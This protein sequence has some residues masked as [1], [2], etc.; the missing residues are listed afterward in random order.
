[1]RMSSPLIFI[2][3]FAL[4][5]VDLCWAQD[6]TV[7]LNDTRVTTSPP[8]LKSSSNWYEPT[9]GGIYW[10]G[11]QGDSV[12]LTF[13]GVRAIA[14]FWLSSKGQIAQIALD[15]ANIAQFS[16]QRPDTLSVQCI[17]AQWISNPLSFGEHT[18]TV[19]KI[20]V[21]EYVRMSS[22]VY[23]SPLPSP[24]PSRKSNKTAIIAGSVGGGVGLILILAIAAF[25]LLKRKKSK[26][27]PEPEKKPIIDLLP[28]SPIGYSSQQSPPISPEPMSPALSYFAQSESTESAVKGPRAIH[29]K[30]YPVIPTDG[31]LTESQVEW[32][33]SLQAQNLPAPTLAT[34]I[35]SLT[36]AGGTSPGGARANLSRSPSDG[37]PAASGGAHRRV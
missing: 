29:T 33:Q 12:S 8:S 18:V 5:L 32:L 28:T 10:L 7:Y 23:T 31:R 11:S 19:T 25:L 24:T 27:A 15:G 30:A 13:R 36:A 20:G 17:A 4:L 22:F 21:D 2:S 35:E 26:K 3:L 37:W 6:V 9:C 16:T 1:L 14:N 34:I